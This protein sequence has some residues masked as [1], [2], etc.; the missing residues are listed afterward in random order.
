MGWKKSSEKRD[1]IRAEEHQQTQKKWTRKPE[2]KARN[3][4]QLKVVLGLRSERGKK[5]KEVKRRTPRECLFVG[6][7]NRGFISTTE[8]NLE[9]FC[10][11]VESQGDEEHRG[12]THGDAKTTHTGGKVRKGEGELRYFGRLF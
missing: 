2:T 7:Q 6:L 4:L 8:T 12:S 9:M 5:N 1:T 3:R 11:L 10:S